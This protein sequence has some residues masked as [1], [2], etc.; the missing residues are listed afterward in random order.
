MKEG[1]TVPALPV[2]CAINEHKVSQGF[3]KLFDVC[4]VTPP[5]KSDI[6]LVSYANYPDGVQF[7]ISWAEYVMH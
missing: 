6:P 1:I 2:N 3:D 5:I 7:G 4:A